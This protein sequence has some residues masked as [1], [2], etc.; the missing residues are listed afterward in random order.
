MIVVEAG[1][2]LLFGQL[3]DIA[4]QPR[5]ADLK[6]V[7]LGR[8]GPHLDRRLHALRLGRHRLRSEVEGNTKN[9]RILD[10]EQPLLV[11]F[12]RLPAQRA[13]DHLLAQQLRPESANA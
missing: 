7:A 12:I 11:Q 9:V 3:H 6:C 8:D 10:V 5:E 2:E 4:I 1:L 13:A